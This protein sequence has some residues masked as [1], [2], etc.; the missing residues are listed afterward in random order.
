[1]PSNMSFNTDTVRRTPASPSPFA[2]CRLTL[3]YTC[4]FPGFTLHRR[5]SVGTQFLRLAF[6]CRFV[7]FAFGLACAGSSQVDV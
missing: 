4:A 6:P 7:A 3:R 2:R 1:M 5:S